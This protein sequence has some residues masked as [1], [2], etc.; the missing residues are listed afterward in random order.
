MLMLEDG[1]EGPFKAILSW[2]DEA[3]NR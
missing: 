1:W 3:T 2:L